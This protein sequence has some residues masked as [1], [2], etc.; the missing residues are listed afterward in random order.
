MDDIIAFAAA[1]KIRNDLLL[2][3]S[4]EEENVFESTVLA[5]VALREKASAILPRA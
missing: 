1:G 3:L 4:N 5:V 2:L